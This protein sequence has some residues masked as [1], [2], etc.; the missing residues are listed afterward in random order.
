MCC[1]LYEH[2]KTTMYVVLRKPDALDFL[3]RNV[4]SILIV[5]GS[6]AN[7]LWT[8]PKNIPV[9]KGLNGLFYA[10]INL[11]RPW[12]I[13]INWLERQFFSHIWTCDDVEQP[14]TTL[15]HKYKK[16]YVHKVILNVSPTYPS[17]SQRVT[18]Y[19]ARGPCL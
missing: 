10:I 2:A 11:Y 9:P 12:R 3:K 1:W 19:F 17:H 16:K 6:R 18:H 4:S 5:S 15:Y 8:L 14:S 13:L 7:D